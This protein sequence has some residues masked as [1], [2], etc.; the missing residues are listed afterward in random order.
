MF[1]SRKFVLLLVFFVISL[2]TGVTSE[3][4]ESHTRLKG[5]SRK[6]IKVNKDH[7]KNILLDR[8][9]PYPTRSLQKINSKKKGSSSLSA[10]IDPFDDEDVNGSVTLKFKKNDGFSI[11]LELEDG[12]EDA[13]DC[14]IKIHKGD[15]CD[16]LGSAL[17]DIDWSENEFDFDEDGSVD[18]TLDLVFDVDDDE[19]DDY[20]GYEID[21]FECLFVVIYGPEEKKKGKGGKGKGS[22]KSSR[23]KLG[24]GQLVKSKK[25]CDRRLV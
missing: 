2:V 23:D 10:D 11:S 8:N 19:D 20:A 18:K 15:D 9:D 12:P 4:R 5:G 16:D 17:S 7:T 3:N 1:T 6:T 22:K 13:E 24:C 14:Q 25:S 21:D